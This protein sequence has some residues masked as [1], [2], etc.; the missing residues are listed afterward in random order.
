MHMIF[1]TQQNS[2][3]NVVS[4]KTWVVGPIHCLYMT[5]TFC[6]PF[7]FLHPLKDLNVTSNLRCIL[8]LIKL[9][10][11]RFHNLVNFWNTFMHMIFQTQQN[12]LTNVVS[13]KTWVV[14]PMH[15]LYM[16]FTFCTPFL[17]LA[18]LKRLKWTQIPFTNTP[19]PLPQSERKN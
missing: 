3:T 18:S 1:Q 14:G 9:R 17:L 13:T 5:F 7:Y 15:C 12:S 16:D 8:N 10:T 2:L 19:A 6:T 11:Q 4:T